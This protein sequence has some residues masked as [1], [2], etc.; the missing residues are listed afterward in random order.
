MAG[1]F[2]RLFGGGEVAL[3]VGIHALLDPL[4]CLLVIITGFIC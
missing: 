3:A 1:L 4:L 2:K